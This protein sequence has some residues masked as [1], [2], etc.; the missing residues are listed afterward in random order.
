MFCSRVSMG[1]L[2]LD[3]RHN[4]RKFATGNSFQ[5]SDI[6]K[7]EPM[8]LQLAIFQTSENL[9]ELNVCSSSS[10]GCWPSEFPE[11]VVFSMSFRR[12]TLL[13]HARTCQKILLQSQ[14]LWSKDKLAKWREIK[15][16]LWKETADQ[17]PGHLTRTRIWNHS[18]GSVCYYIVCFYYMQV[19]PLC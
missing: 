6:K 17:W 9:V 10:I 1:H 5:K 3:L 16:C 15:F 7:H 14:A 2:L 12:Y 11:P 18:C 13:E 19:V 8:H 4:D